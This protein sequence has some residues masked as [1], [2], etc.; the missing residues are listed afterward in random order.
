MVAVRVTLLLDNFTIDGSIYV[1]PELRR[2]SDAWE[3]L[4]RDQRSFIPVT[5]ARIDRIS[6]GGTFA[7]PAFMQ[8]KKSDIRGVFPLE[9]PATGPSW[10]EA[11][12]RR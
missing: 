9:L 7:S 10:P 4:V 8:V 3:A 12:S 5:D 1:A 6:D 11:P 2:F